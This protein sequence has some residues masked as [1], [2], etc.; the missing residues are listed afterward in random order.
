MV[1]NR[2]DLARGYIDKGPARRYARTPGRQEGTKKESL[3]GLA[4]FN[5]LIA[6]PQ[7]GRRMTGRRSSFFTL[8]DGAKIT[9][10]N[11]AIL[12]RTPRVLAL[13]VST[14]VIKLG[15]V[16][17]HAPYI[18]Q[19]GRGAWWW[20]LAATVRTMRRHTANVFMGIDAN[21]H[22]SQSVEPYIGNFAPNPHPDPFENE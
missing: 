7:V 4:K 21:L 13:I 6:P 12:A 3:N 16:A 5:T 20:E 2:P 10:D 14:D 19:E 8:L 11:I 18:G 22:F 15:I 1:T 17:A 9:S